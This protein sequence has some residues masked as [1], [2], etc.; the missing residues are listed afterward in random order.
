MDPDRAP[1]NAVSD[2]DLHC[3]CRSSGGFSNTHRRIE[4]WTCLDCSRRSGVNVS[5]YFG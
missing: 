1:Q 5:E 2:L 4:G 3:L